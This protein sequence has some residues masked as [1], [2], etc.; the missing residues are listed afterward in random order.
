ML[1]FDGT[2]APIRPRPG[3]VRLSRPARA[4][5]VRLAKHPQVTVCIVSGRRLTD[6]RRR[7]GVAR[8]R[9]VG[10]HGGEWEG[11]NSAHVEDGFLRKAKRVLKERLEDLPGIWLEDKRISLAV[12]Y[13]GAAPNVMRRAHAL[14]R[15]TLKPSGSYLRTMKGKKVWEVLPP[16]VEG[17]GE[18]ARRILAN[19]P[20]A[21]LPVYV[22]DDTSDEPAFSELSRG[23]TIHV[24]RRRLTNARYSLRD[25]NDVV[26]FLKALEAEFT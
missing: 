5:L 12:H 8:A 26:D 20:E 11:R 18:A 6:L 15:Q 17:K 16:D 23:I 3:M 2:L 1:D 21:T 22:G 25:P 13:R 24:G 9:Y 14:L 7:A 4:L 19:F 10:V